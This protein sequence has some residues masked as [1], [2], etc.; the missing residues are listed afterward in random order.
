MAIIWWGY[1]SLPNSK[2]TKMRHF[3][4]VL[5]Q[6]TTV[7]LLDQHDL[8]CINSFV[9]VL[10]KLSM[11]CGGKKHSFSDFNQQHGLFWILEGLDYSVVIYYNKWLLQNCSQTCRPSQQ[12][13]PCAKS[14]KPPEGEF[15]PSCTG[16]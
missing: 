3:N 13:W 1:Y 6:S 8:P 7:T 12:A 2:N 14:L 10:K 11:K 4:T 9:K 15:F 16:S 5:K